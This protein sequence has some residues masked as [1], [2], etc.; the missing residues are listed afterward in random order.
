MNTKEE[1]EF[2]CEQEISEHKH[3]MLSVLDSQDQLIVTTNGKTL[4]SVN[5]T[6]LDFFAV[7]SIDEFKKEYATNSIHTIFNNNA[8]DDYLKES[9][10]TSEWVNNIVNKESTTSFKVMIHQGNSDFSFSVTGT[11]LPGKK[12]LKALFFTNIT[13]IETA[14]KTNDDILK[15]LNSSIEYASI[16]QGTLV[17]DNNI[18]RKYFSDYF[19]IWHPKDKVGGDI[20]LFEELRH[21]DECLLMV[22]DCTGHGVPGA[23]VTMLVKAI[24][25]E[26]VSLIKAD[27]TIDVSP[28]YILSYFNKTMKKLLKQ[29][30]KNSVTISNAGFDGQIIYYNRNDKIL[31]FAS[32]R[33]E[34]YYY[35]DD[36]LELIKGDRHSVGYKDSEV[37]YKFT[38][39]IIDVSKD[40]TLYLSTDGYLDQ[41]GGQKG[42]PFGKKRLKTLLNE[43]HSESMADQQEEFLYTLHDYQGAFEKNDDIT[44]FGI[45][46]EGNR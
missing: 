3:F 44:V 9:T 40:T 30:S 34:L 5:E 15:R 20:Y 14:K 37:E 35:Q 6:F 46:I 41:N 43:I 27:D 23:F 33:N 12:N 45:K 22:I 38:D 24:E 25:R 21:D 2:D 31:K 13:E 16:I 32:A 39:H 42:F 18:F 11:E 26:V 19:L 36:K 1:I 17:P 4:N 8:P 10:C 28:A 7:E 29:E